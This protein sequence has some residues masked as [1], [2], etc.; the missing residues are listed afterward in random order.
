MNEDVKRVFDA[1]AELWSGRWENFNQRRI[2][3]WKLSLAIWGAATAFIIGCISGKFPQVGLPVLYWTIA[4][5]G[6]IA[7]LHITWLYGLGVNNENDRTVM[8]DYEERM[9]QLVLADF[10]PRQFEKSGPLLNWSHGPQVGITLLLYLGAILAAQTIIK[11]Y[12]YPWEA[13]VLAS[14]GPVLVFLLAWRAVLTRP[15]KRLRRWREFF[16]KKIW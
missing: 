10:K 15:E 5:A 4:I 14:G 13:A 12:L 1:L 6:A 8:H 11:E 16:S 9:R 7:V 3:E 2:Y